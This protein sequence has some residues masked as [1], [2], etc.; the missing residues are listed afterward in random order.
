MITEYYYNEAKSVSLLGTKQICK[1]P[2]PPPTTTTTI[3]TTTHIHFISILI[4]T[5]PYFTAKQI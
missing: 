2:P 3:T 1:K 4:V 5:L